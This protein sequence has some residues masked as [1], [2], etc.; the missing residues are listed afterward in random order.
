M[1]GHQPQGSSSRTCFG[2]PRLVLILPELLFVRRGKS[3]ESLAICELSRLGG[4]PMR[5]PAAGL[6]APRSRKIE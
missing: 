6:S 2:A 3:G 4:E 5:A 1:N